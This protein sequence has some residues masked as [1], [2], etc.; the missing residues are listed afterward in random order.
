MRQVPHPVAIITST[1]IHQP[2]AI[3]HQWRGATVSSFNTVT[4]DPEP[5]VSFNI[6]QKSA[7]YSAIKAS[8]YFTVHA[9]SDTTDA[10]QLATRFA[11][12]N[13]KLPFHDGQGG[14]CGFVSYTVLEPGEAKQSSEPKRVPPKINFST[15][16]ATAARKKDLDLDFDVETTTP[17]EKPKSN[18]VRFRLEC[19]FLSDKTVQIGDHVV[20]F[21]RVIK[22]EAPSDGGSEQKFPS[23][24]HRCLVYAH[25]RYGRMDEFPP[26]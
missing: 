26:D 3:E 11:A 14:I 8:N 13:Q 2:G 16:D 1:H 18:L 19:E 23:Q 9:L 17:P 7:T 24:H 22:A 5:V 10:G 4:L 6:K 15:S 21:G 20:V 25:Q 12:G